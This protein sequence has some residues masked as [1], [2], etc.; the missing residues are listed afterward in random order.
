MILFNLKKNLKNAWLD[1]LIRLLWLIQSQVAPGHVH[2]RF[3][4]RLKLVKLTGLEPTSLITMILPKSQ[5]K[6]S[7]KFNQWQNITYIDLS[8][9]S[10]LKWWHDNNMCIMTLTSKQEKKGTLI[11]ERVVHICISSVLKKQINYQL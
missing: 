7:R 4:T 9:T 5:G 2:A 8:R 3:N 10:R 1:E 6:S 11:E